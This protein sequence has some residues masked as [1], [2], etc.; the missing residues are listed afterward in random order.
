MEYINQNNLLI[1]CTFICVS[2]NVS[3]VLL[4]PFLLFE[5]ISLGQ[6]S[7][8]STN[9]PMSS[10]ATSTMKDLNV[11][12]HMSY[13]HDKYTVPADKAPS[14]TFLFNVNHISSLQTRLLASRFS[15][16]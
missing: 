14:I 7:Q 3:C 10:R 1:Q 13:L 5:T 6:Y 16:M 2:F 8:L 4:I 11:T 12:K 9:E 15:C